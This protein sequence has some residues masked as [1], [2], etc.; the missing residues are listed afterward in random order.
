MKNNW[1]KATAIVGIW[2]GVGISG[3]FAPDAVPIVALCAF[4][5]TAFTALLFNQ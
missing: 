1:A 5:G 2:L 4:F 3:I